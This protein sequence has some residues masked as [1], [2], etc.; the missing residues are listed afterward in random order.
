MNGPFSG[1]NECS[2]GVRGAEGAS[3][4]QHITGVIWSRKEG[5][6]SLAT[7][8]QAGAY[9]HRDEAGLQVPGDGLAGEPGAGCGGK[10]LL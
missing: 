10:N 4:N 3:P 9:R 7:H 2:A 6:F 5:L 1:Q 8:E